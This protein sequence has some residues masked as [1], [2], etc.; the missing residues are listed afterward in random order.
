M[1]RRYEDPVMLEEMLEEAKEILEEMRLLD[2]DEDEI[3]DQ[4]LYVAEL[5]DRVRFAWDDEQYDEMYA[6]D[7]FEEDIWY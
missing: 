2:Y 6:D 4:E 3:I 1:F 7:P 5:K